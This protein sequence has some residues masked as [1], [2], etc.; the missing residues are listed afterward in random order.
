MELVHE[1]QDTRHLLKHFDADTCD[2]LVLDISFPDSDGLDMLE[3]L[4]AVWPALKILVMSMHPEE[5]YAL[6]AMKT[7]ARGYIS[8]SSPSVELIDAIR[9]IARGARYYSE[10]VVDKMAGGYLEQSSDKP[11]EQ[12]TNREFQVF[13]LLARG[14]SVQEI[15]RLLV[16]SSNTV[17]TFR[18][19]IFDK[20]DLQTNA[21]LIHYAVQNNLVN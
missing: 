11:H 21:G 10:K 9:K 13:M 12:L 6:R 8:K 15:S 4:R 5:Q 1:Y 16:L 19:R 18:R 17:Y 14:L 2:I 20:M 7:G 3:R